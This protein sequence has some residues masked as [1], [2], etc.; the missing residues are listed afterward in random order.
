MRRL[1]VRSGNRDRDVRAKVIANRPSSFQASS[2]SR[3]TRY[4]AAALFTGLALS[5]QALLVPFFGAGPNA[6]PFIVFFA[7]VMA[8]AWF[9]GLGPGLLATA[10][11]ALLSWYFFLSPQFSFAL[12][13]AG[14]A[15]RLLVFAAEGAFISALAGAMHRSRERAEDGALELLG[16]EARLRELARQQ[17][18][19]AGL[20]RRALGTHDLQNLMDEAATSLA[21]VLGV[22]YAKVLEVLP[23][24]EDLLLRSG[25]GWKEGLVGRTTVGAGRDSQAGY[26]LLSDEP[27]VVDDLRSEERFA[28]PPLLREHG[29]VSGMSTVVGGRE[30]PYGVLGAHTRERRTFTEDDVNFLAA[31]ANVLAAAIERERAEAELREGEERFKATFEQAAVGVAHVSPDGGWI[32]VNDRLC[33]IVGHPRKELLGKTFQDITHPD[34]LDADLVQA[35]QLLVGEIDTYSMEKRYVRKDGSV[36]WTNLTG[37]LVRNARGEPSY[38]IAV[39]EDI[40]ERKR[41]EEAVREIRKAER[42]RMAR[43]L[44]DGVLQDLSYTAATMGLMMLSVDDPE[45]KGRL[46]GSIDAVRRAAEGLRDA[47]EDLR[48]EGDEDRDLPELLGSLLEEA[49]A[50]NP[51]CEIRLEAQD[52]FPSQLPEE[53]RVQLSRVVREALTNVRRHSGAENV[54]VSLRTEGDDL[55]VEV[56]DDGRGFGTKIRTGGGT[57]SMRE[58]AAALG[59]RLEVESEP[60]RRSTVRLRVPKSK[61]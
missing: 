19:V 32:R 7:A 25:V 55:I 43:D 21:E 27:V 15:L 12:G 29:V 16:R 6:S 4:G 60:G 30:R 2:R 34:D 18:A 53:T 48:L 22:E 1:V 8:S 28:G 56:S 42:A 3:A 37:S 47:V 9:G 50:M 5:L 40:S 57:R 52:G 51:G 46:Q 58:R 24:D 45:L 23:G 39:V 17:A 41:A 44:H 33:E 26:T 38:F 10:L 31:V 61:A 20:G 59:G 14:Q 54:S 13:G 36:V 49:R 11:S 35:G